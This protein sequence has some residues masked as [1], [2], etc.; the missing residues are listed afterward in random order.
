MM[1]LH[2]PWRLISGCRR[3]WLAMLG[4][5]MLVFSMA[6]AHA[7]ADAHVESHYREA[8]Y[9]IGDVIDEVVDITATPGATLVEETLPRSGDGQWI[10]LREVD[11]QEN[12]PQHGRFKLHLRWQLF[13]ALRETRTIPLPAFTVNLRHGQTVLP[14]KI[15][16]RQVMVSPLLPVILDTSQTSLRP[17][18]LPPLRDTAQPMRYTLLAL[19]LTLTAALWLLWRH[20]KPP[21]RWAP[22]GPFTSACR[23]LR[24]RQ[25][26]KLSL[27]Q[28]FAV[29]HHAFNQTAGRTVFASDVPV[30]LKLRPELARLRPEIEAFYARSARVFFA[31]APNAASADDV[32]AIKTLL[33]A[34]R[35]LERGRKP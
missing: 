33:A 11:V 13:K 22:A 28:S 4:Q 8:G 2:R 32:A 5:A 31:E 20:D 19:A 35:A 30:L 16:E 23:R 17:D 29:A 1:P 25:G 27:A 34:C 10:E 9:F 26:R 7:A 12:A 3:A 14:V 15:H 6:N 21:F 24:G 18:S